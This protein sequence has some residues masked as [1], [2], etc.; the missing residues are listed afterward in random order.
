MGCLNDCPDIVRNVAPLPA[1]HLSDI[2]DH[3]QLTGGIAEGLTRLGL[4][5]R[6]D[7]TAVREADGRADGHR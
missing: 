4:L 7:V 5:D 2:D 3:V 1:Q 6:R